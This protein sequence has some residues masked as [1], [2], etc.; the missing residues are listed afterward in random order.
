M[1]VGTSTGGEEVADSRIAAEEYCIQ[2]RAGSCA[3]MRADWEQGTSSYGGWARC[4][5]WVPYVLRCVCSTARAV[6]VCSAPP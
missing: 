2:R 1:S 5:C 3:H 4:Q 6:L